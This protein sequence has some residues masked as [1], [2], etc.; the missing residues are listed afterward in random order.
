MK[1]FTSF[2]LV[3]ESLRSRSDEQKGLVKIY[4][5]ENNEIYR[6]SSLL[7]VFPLISAKLQTSAA[8]CGIHIEISTSL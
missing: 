1:A 2:T 3:G 4:D 6:N 5:C 8:S 7:T